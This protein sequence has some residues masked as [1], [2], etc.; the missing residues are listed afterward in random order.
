MKRL[1]LLLAVCAFFVCSMAYAQTTK[2]FVH[3]AAT[4]GM[5]EVKAGELAQRKGVSPRVKEFGARMVHDHTK[6][7][8]E[9]MAIVKRKGM[10]AELPAPGSVMGDPMLEKAS[11]K[12]FDR[13]Y[14]TM[15][16]SDHKEAVALF[17][18]AARNERD[19]EIKMFAKNTLPKLR[20][21][22]EAIQ[23]IATEMH[24]SAR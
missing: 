15:M 21:H 24:I 16:V 20:Q 7:N 5:K 2:E 12:E 14:V 11:G 18:N 4:A 22:L 10:S 23:S 9:L 1:S 19:P 8:E 6:A 3:K 17:E 13:M